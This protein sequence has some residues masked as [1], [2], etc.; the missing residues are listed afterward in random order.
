MTC[1]TC[2]REYKDSLNIEAI[3][4]LGECLSCDHSRGEEN[5]LQEEGENEYDNNE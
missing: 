2:V 1:F 5:L 3:L 4:C